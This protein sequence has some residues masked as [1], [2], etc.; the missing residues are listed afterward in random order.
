LPGIAHYD[1]VL[2]LFPGDE[3]MEASARMRIANDTATPVTAIPLLLY[4]LLDVTQVTQGGADVPFSQD[5]VKFSDVPTRQ[6]NLVSITLPQPLPA[7]ASTDIHVAYNGPVYG[8][9]EVE[10]YV[11][12]RIDKN[13]GLV[14][15]DS[16]SYP[17]LANPARTSVHAA[18]DKLFTFNL[19][20]TV[21]TGYTVASGGSLTTTTSYGDWTTFVYE[22]TTPT[23]RIDIASAHFRVFRDEAN[24]L[25]V[26][27]MEEDLQAASR[28]L[29]AMKRATA[30]Y[31]RMFG[32]VG[33]SRGYTAIEIPDGWGSQAA[34][35][36]FL[37]A[38][39]AFRD[40]T[41]IKEVFHEVA[42]SWNLEPVREVQRTRFFDE[43]F[44]SYFESLS[45]R[46]YEGQEA[47]EKD[48]EDSRK[49]FVQWGEYDKKNFETPIV[50]YGRYELGR[51]SYTKGAWSLY[52]L[53]RLV[54]EGKFLELIR[55]LRAAFGNK[56]I[57]FHDFQRTVER[58]AGRSLDRYF[59]E[60]FYGTESSRLLA[61]QTAID[62]IVMRYQ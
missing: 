58:T 16:Y 52:V 30:L 59:Q 47:F 36:Y 19:E 48:M 62:R 21:P 24:G 53:H 5:I 56:P 26:Y 43:A 42:H 54:G 22:R 12:D 17:L 8:Y 37:Q 6:V 32:A 45:V 18:L 41:R 4:R 60:W 15:Q 61:E 39:A 23:W 10:A 11:K 40:P 9:P 35:G 46:E 38:A 7:G 57:D 14:R 49:L 50:D 3:R 31:T 34:D 55:A 20:V 29:D 27:A 44:A 33:N 1:L 28:I 51:N 2:R 13:F 25:T